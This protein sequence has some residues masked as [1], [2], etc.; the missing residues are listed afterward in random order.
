MPMNETKIVCKEDTV[1]DANGNP[2]LR[3][4]SYRTPV[5]GKSELD[6]LSDQLNVDKLTSEQKRDV[7]LVSIGLIAA[8]TLVIGFVLLKTGAVNVA[9]T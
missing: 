8:A 2:S 7:V 5:G 3:I 1:P 9:R 4:S 6:S